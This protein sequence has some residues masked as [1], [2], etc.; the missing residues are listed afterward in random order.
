VSGQIDFARSSRGPKAGT[1]PCTAAAASCLS[2][3]PFARDAVS[4]AYFDHGLNEIATLTTA[5]LQQLYSNTTTGSITLANGNIVK[6][7]ITQQGS[8]TTGFWET[9][10]GITDATAQAASAASGCTANPSLLEENG[11][12]Q[13]Y[14]FASTLPAGQDAVVDF[15][16]GSWISQANGAALDRSATARANF[17]DMGAIDAL[18]KPYTGTAPNEA[19]NTTF[20]N[21]TTYGRNL[22]VVV[23]TSRLGT[24][25]D[26]GL[27]SLFLGASAAVCSASA[28]T[29]AAKFGFDSTLVGG[30]CGTAVTAN[31]YS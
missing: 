19:P 5:Q 18:G 9:A 28:Q 13:F 16:V 1:S 15:S 10:L 11:A 29:T 14:T 25:G 20:Y 27:K 6:A 4:F 12:N 8:G 21:S 30:T 31:L 17:V 7:C 2:F 3:I 23:Q 22:Q 24:F 26:A